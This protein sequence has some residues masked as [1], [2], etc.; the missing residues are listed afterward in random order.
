MLKLDSPEWYTLRDAYGSAEKIP[1]LLRRL[2]ANPLDKN[3]L[4]DAWSSLCHQGTIYSASIPAIPHLVML[5]TDLQLKD[6]LEPL[7]LAGCIASNIR[8]SEFE[9]D[10]ELDAFVRAGLRSLLEAIE[11]AGLTEDELRYSLSGVAA[12]KGYPSLAKR[13]DFMEDE[14]EIQ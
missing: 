1:D 14:D 12:F 2:Y 13:I 10:D 5:S 3:A 4:N 8:G 6:R 7:L 9:V 11:H